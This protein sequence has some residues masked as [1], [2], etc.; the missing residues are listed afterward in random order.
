M[1]LSKGSEP[2]RMHLDALLLVQM[3]RQTT[4]IAISTEHD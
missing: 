1:S 2:G 4:A 3:L